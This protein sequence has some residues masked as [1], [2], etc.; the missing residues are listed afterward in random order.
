MQIF[1][2]CK[3]TLHVSGA[4]APIIKILKTVHAASGTGH[5]ICKATALQR[6]LSPGQSTLEGSSGTSSMTC[7]GGCVYSFEYS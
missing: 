2:Y 4:T 5:T 7:T 3:A 6:G 1:I